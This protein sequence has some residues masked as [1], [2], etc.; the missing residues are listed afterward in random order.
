V[1]LK[2]SF[3]FFVE[4]VEINVTLSV[5]NYMVVICKNTYDKKKLTLVYIWKGSLDNDYFDNE[6][7]NKYE[8][9]L[10]NFKNRKKSYE[11]VLILID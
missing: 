5:Y 3:F 2:L 11:Y 6:F 4:V 1:L 7:S 9:N 8:K 10:K